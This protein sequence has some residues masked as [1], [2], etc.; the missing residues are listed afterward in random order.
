MRHP[1]TFPNLVYGGPAA[2]SKMV[3]DYPHRIITND[4]VM[5]LWDEFP[6]DILDWLN[7]NVGDDG[8]MRL[9]NRFFF[10]DDAQAALFKLSFGK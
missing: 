8:W 9:E 7:D 2:Y 6:A 1:N 3:S 4:K 5:A 10:K